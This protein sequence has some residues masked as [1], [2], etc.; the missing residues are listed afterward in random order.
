MAADIIASP[1]DPTSDIAALKQVN[2]VMK[3]GQVVRDR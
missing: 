2:F 3:D 1:G